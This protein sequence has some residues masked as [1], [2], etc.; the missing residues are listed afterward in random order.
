MIDNPILRMCPLKPYHLTMILEEDFSN[1]GQTLTKMNLGQPNVS[2]QE[3]T[4]DLNEESKDLK[5]ELKAE[6]KDL[7][8]ELKA[9]SKDLTK[10]L[11]D[12]VQ[13]QSKDL[14]K[15][16]KKELPIL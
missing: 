4:E 11:R 9:E 10:D 1:S 5:S 12:E 8:A 14:V 3:L 16:I 15:D 6:S 13:A 7:K 2:A